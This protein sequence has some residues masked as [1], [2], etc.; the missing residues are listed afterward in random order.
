MRLHFTA[1][2]GFTRPAQFFGW[3]CLLENKRAS[4][5]AKDLLDFEPLLE[6]ARSP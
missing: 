5:R 4:N 1:T 2:P 3:D 6:I